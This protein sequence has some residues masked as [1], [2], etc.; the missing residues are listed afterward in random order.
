MKKQFAMECQFIDV[1]KIA[2]DCSTINNSQCRCKSCLIMPICKT[3]CYN[4]YL[5]W[6][7]T[8]PAPKLSEEKFKTLIQPYL[9]C[10]K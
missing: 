1:C 6:Y 8:I 9:I 4:R 2:L 3:V 7:T 5:E 10:R